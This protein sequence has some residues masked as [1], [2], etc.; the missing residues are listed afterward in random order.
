MSEFDHGPLQRYEIIWKSGHVEEIAC[1]QVMLPALSML[2][3]FGIETRE[4]SRRLTLHGQID[5]H[6]KLILD[7]D[8]DDISTIRLLGSMQDI[9]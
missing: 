1:H 7:A 8:Y 6:W 9:A 5:G 3:L 2:P 4:P